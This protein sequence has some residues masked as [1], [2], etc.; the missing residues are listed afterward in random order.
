LSSKLSRCLSATAQN[1]LNC[2]VG[3]ILRPFSSGA[4]KLSKWI[5]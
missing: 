3:S 4:K 5:G 1:S 2:A